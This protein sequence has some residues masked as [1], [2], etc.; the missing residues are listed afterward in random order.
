MTRELLKRHP[1]SW[2]FNRLNIPAR[3][4]L[5]ASIPHRFSLFFAAHQTLK[6]LQRSG[7]GYQF[8][9]IGPIIGQ[10]RPFSSLGSC[11]GAG[12]AGS[13]SG[14]G[15]GASAADGNAEHA[16][17]DPMHMHMDNDFHNDPQDLDLAPRTIEV[18][19]RNLVLRPIASQSMDESEESN[20]NLEDDENEISDHVVSEELEQKY[21]DRS[22]IEEK[23][24]NDLNQAVPLV[25]MF[26]LMDD[27][28]P[29]DEN[30]EVEEN[31]EA[32][33]DVED[34]EDGIFWGVLLLL[35]D[36]LHLAIFL[37]C[38]F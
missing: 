19:C 24:H 14:S 33:E 5:K 29:D 28:P 6:M 8:Q 17:L 10:A 30:K 11:V 7:Y 32:E 25:G 13:I 34:L 1:C 31:D 22:A 12:S 23:Y 21:P 2:V 27:N 37:L 18:N 35:L 4:R 15:A 16:D 9:P 20:V 3:A 38:F 36:E 26:H